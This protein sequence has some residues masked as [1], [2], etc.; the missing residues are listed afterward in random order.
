MQVEQ[1][2][3]G[4][5]Q[6]VLRLVQQSDGEAGRIEA[7]V[8]AAFAR[9]FEAGLRVMGEHNRRTVEAW[10]RAGVTVV[11][12]ATTWVDVTSTDRCS[13]GP[14]GSDVRSSDGGVVSTTM[15]SLVGCSVASWLGSMPG[16]MKC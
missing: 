8:L 13:T 6:A 4:V 10:M 12:P 9:G 2:T 7:A 11:D 5:E 15:A 14:S 16:F 1:V 3:R